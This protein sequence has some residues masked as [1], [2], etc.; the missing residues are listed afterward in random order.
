MV[1]GSH[2]AEVAALIMEKEKEGGA[3]YASGWKDAESAAALGR[4]LEQQLATPSRTHLS[5]LEDQN[6][7]H[8]R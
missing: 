2:G 5:E 7:V 8:R 4:P 1:F 3:A 6:G